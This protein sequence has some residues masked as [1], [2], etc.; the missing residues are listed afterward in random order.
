M[1]WLIAA[2]SAC[3]LYHGDVGGPDVLFDTVPFIIQVEDRQYVDDESLD[4]EA[5]LADMEQTAAASRT[6][7]PSPSRGRS[8][9]PRRITWSPSPYRATF[10]AA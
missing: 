3:D 1:S 9:S 10:P 8:F 4:V 2:D 7:C 5:M 6:A